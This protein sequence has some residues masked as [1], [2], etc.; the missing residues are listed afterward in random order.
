MDIET[1]LETSPAGP[2]IQ[3]RVIELGVRQPMSERE[4]RCDV[5]SVVPTIAHKDTFSVGHR[6]DI[7]D[8]MPGYC[9][10][11]PA[12]GRSLIDLGKVSGSLPEK[13][14]SPQSN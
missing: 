5:L 9:A 12:V 7:I 10:I 11:E 1:D 14:T 6:A 8:R 2:D 4:Q 13:L 3:V